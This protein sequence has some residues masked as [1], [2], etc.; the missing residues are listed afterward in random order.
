MKMTRSALP[1]II[2]TALLSAA[3]T[4]LAQDWPQW[5]GPH[6][7]AV[8][9]GFKAPAAWPK[10]LTQ[11]W[12]VAI[13]TGDATPALVGDKLYVF[14]RQGDE[15][16]V[17]CLDAATGKELWKD[18]HAEKAVAGAASGHPGPRSSPA[19]ADG[20][21][22][23]LSV[24]SIL[25]VF[26]A[27]TG[28]VLWRGDQGHVGTPRFF[29]AASPLI[30]DGKIIVHLGTES[31]GAL[32]ACDLDGNPKWKWTGDGPGY[33]SP[34]T[35]TVG[36]TTLI[37]TQTAKFMLA[38]NAADGKEVWKADFP[39]A[40]M[41]YNAASPV[42]DGQTLYYTGQG[43]G[44]HAIKFDQADDAITAKELWANAQVSTQ[45]NTP[46]LKDGHL[47]ALA[48]GGG[49]GR[50]NP[51][52]GTAPAGPGADAGRLELFA[53]PTATVFTAAPAAPAGGGGMGGMG[54]GRRGGGGMRGGAGNFVCLDAKTGQTAWTDPTPRGTTYGSLVDA[55]PVLFALVEGAQ[56]SVF[57]PDA[58]A[59]KEVATYKVSAKKTYA[60]PVISGNR[61][62]IRDQDSVT[63]Y[64]LE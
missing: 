20:K 19:V 49:G 23:T 54:S 31:G 5:R 3:L 51:A 62:F 35:M 13:G 45:Y 28:K 1:A 16:V 50:M 26:D 43:R 38:V 10:E 32:I 56:L 34:A 27:A 2:A 30:V 33:A 39:V 18:A 9:T 57:T 14:G 48:M 6:R 36:K 7:D 22:V 42:I 58:T 61:I 41:G 52:P 37:I 59:Y 55:G 60:Y 47:Y 21:L 29:T 44:M 25:S 63:L 53:L 64:S 11:K 46:V 24:S 17:R 4:A 12:N 15:E 8:A 40:G